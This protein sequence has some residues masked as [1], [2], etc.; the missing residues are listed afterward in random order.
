VTACHTPEALDTLPDALPDARLLAPAPP[1]EEA[2]RGYRLLAT[3]GVTQALHALARQAEEALDVALEALPRLTEREPCCVVTSSY[4]FP[5][6]GIGFGGISYRSSALLV[7]TGR[8]VKGQQ[9]GGKA[10]GREKALKLRTCK[11]CVMW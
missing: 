8:K 5:A 1:V 11:T 4:T 7:T 9:H 3:A 2:P 10:G 6:T